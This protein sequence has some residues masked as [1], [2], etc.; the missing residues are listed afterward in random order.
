MSETTK[1]HFMAGGLCISAELPKEQAEKLIR[2]VSEF[3]LQ[4]RK[5]AQP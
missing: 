2:L 3:V 1:V 5:E 4:A